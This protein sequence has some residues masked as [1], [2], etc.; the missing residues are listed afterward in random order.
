MR[1]PALSFSIALILL[2]ALSSCNG[3]SKPAGEPAPPQAKEIRKET[4]RGPFC[5]RVL[6]DK[7]SPSIA[8]SIVLTIEAEAPEGYDLELPKF[9]EKLGEFGI[10]TYQD[11]PPRLTLDGRIVSRKV[12]TLD[13]FLS[14]DYVIAPMKATFRKRADAKIAGDGATGDA[15]PE[16]HELATE[17]I[18]IRVH[19]LLEKDQKELTLNPIKGPLALPEGPASIRYILLALGVALAAGG[20]YFLF[21]RG[22]S[23][24]GSL[25][26][27][28][29]PAH[30]LACRQLREIIDSGLVERGEI[31]LF[32][33]KVS[34]VLRNYI[35]NRFGI[36]AP[37]RTTEEFLL[38]IS[39]DAPFTKDLQ[40][41][42]T[43]FL[44]SC[45]LVKFAEHTPLADEISKA[46]ESCKVFIQA[47]RDDSEGQEPAAPEREK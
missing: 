25:S 37:K 29:I 10:R 19:S 31:K 22:R 33:S 4:R 12:Y 2:A 35:E 27:T 42:L 43:E 20:A 41:L 47:T 8:E 11:A 38:D 34:D 24:G 5:F 13:P 26:A 32:F 3:G 40:G 7:D 23:G 18:T 17:E 16:E 46:V 39:R 45:D 6:V 21:K 1:K 30:E 36:H 14:G 9:G 15:A 44:Q 28:V